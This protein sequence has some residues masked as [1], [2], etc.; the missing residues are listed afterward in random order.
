MGF[1]KDGR[2]VIWRSVDSTALG[3]LA[4][5]AAVI[6][7]NDWAPTEDFRLLKMELIAHVKALTTLQGLGLLIG[8]AD[9]ELSVAEIA[10]ALIIDGPDD[11]NDNVGSEQASRPVW[12]MGDLIKD[13]GDAELRGHFRGEGNS[14][15]MTWKKRWTFSAPEG[16]NIFVFNNGS[17]LT[18]GSSCGLLLT[19]YGVWVT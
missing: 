3:A 5:Q 8:I 2:G 19:G 9:A 18:T 14:P 11:R 12:I 7:G 10:E 4:G 15:V 1:G 13:G 16:A 6:V 17:A